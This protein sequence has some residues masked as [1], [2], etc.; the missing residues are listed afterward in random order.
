MDDQFVNFVANILKVDPKILHEHSTANT[1]PGWDSLMHWVVIG[2]LED[3]YDVEFTMDEAT[4]FKDLGDI[5]NMLL[6]KSG[7]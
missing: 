7:K 6:E 1:T 5:Y 2:E 3:A 4:S